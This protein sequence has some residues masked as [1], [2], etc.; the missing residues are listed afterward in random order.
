LHFYQAVWEAAIRT[1]ARLGCDHINALYKFTITYYYK[2]T[3]HLLTW[4][5][6]SELRG[7]PLCQF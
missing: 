6:V 1:L 2:L 7:L 5:V 4:K 3:F